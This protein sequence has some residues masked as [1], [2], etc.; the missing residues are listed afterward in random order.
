MPPFLNVQY[1]TA[2]AGI[3]S[4]FRQSYLALTLYCEKGLMYY[5]NKG[6]DFI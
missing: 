2:G 3:W 1:D 5:R 6:F 4:L